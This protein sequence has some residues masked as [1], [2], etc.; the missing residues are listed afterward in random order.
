MKPVAIVH[1]A[2]TE[3]AGYFATFLDAHSIPWR[4]F[5]LAQGQQ[6]PEVADPF[7]AL[8]LLGDPMSV[9]DP[10]LWINESCTLIRGFVSANLPVIG[11]YL[12]GN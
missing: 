7:S 6:L 5:A 10:L 11:H 9:N 2:R 1:Y 3:G 4:M 12:G 8:Y